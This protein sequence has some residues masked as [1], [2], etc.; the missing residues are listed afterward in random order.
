MNK[1]ASTRARGA[2]R[3]ALVRG[4]FTVLLV[5]LAGL[6]GVVPFF[7]GHENALALVHVTLTAVLLA[8]LY[9]ST[10]RRRDL[11]IAAALMLPGLTGRWLSDHGLSAELQVGA[12]LFTIAFLGF[13]TAGVMK[14]VLHPG[15]VTYDTISGA[16]CAYFLIGVM[17]AFAYLAV[18]LWWPGAFTLTG[19]VA[20]ASLAK[21]HEELQRLIYY[22][23]VTLTTL[24]YGDVIPSNGPARAVSALEAIVGQMYVAILVA[25]LVALHILHSE[26][27]RT[28]D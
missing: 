28:P 5:L 27:E 19:N 8:A 20:L 7:E 15:R 22:S 23:F 11:I 26:R 2:W 17:W 13:V 6:V 21:T 18:E 9:A 16:L 12:A 3:S 4:R 10:R 1:P 14:Q 24:G 25:R